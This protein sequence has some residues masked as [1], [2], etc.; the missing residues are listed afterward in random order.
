MQLLDDLARLRAPT[1]PPSGRAQRNAEKF[2]RILP[3]QTSNPPRLR[4]WREKMRSVSRSEKRVHFFSGWLLAR[5]R[6]ASRSDW[7]FGSYSTFPSLQQADAAP[8]PCSPNLTGELPPP[9][10]ALADFLSRTMAANFDNGK[11]REVKVGILCV[12]DVNFGNG[13]EICALFQYF[14]PSMALIRK[15]WRTGRPARR[16]RSRKVQLGAEVCHEQLSALQRIDGA[17]FLRSPPLRSPLLC[18]FPPR[19]EN[20]R[21]SKES[22]GYHY[23]ADLFFAR[24]LFSPC[25]LCPSL[26]QV[27]VLSACLCAQIGASFMSKLIT[28]NSKPIKF[29]IWD[30]AG[31]EKYH[32]LACTYCFFALA[33]CLRRSCR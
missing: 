12:R 20:S 21:T 25:S 14:L 13:R 30:T 16:H 23:D 5:G 4:F 6:G 7:I 9:R 8:P 32:S 27:A 17:F 31:Q 11:P 26:I 18:S 2:K 28:V 22:D 3:P 19:W 15:M 24:V 1:P 10:P 33:T 29:Q